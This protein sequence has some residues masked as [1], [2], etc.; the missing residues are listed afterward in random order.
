M[1]RKLKV[2]RA[3]AGFHDVYVAAPSQKAALEAWGA[4]HNLFASGAAE[5][6]IDPEL[7]AAALAKPGIVLKVLRGTSAEQ[8]AAL[9]D[10]QE[11]KMRPGS[12]E[13]ARIVPAKPKVGPRPGRAALDAAETAIAE[14][15]ERYRLRKEEL[16]QQE[17]AIERERA[18]LQKSQAKDALD[19]ETARDRAQKTY[20]RAIAE[21][22][23]GAD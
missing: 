8:L 4:S 6:V 5:V 19:A 18:K 3:A 2:F 22:K 17:A 9:G 15:E 7:V 12:K 20:D 23:R 16:D 1:G 10:R 21:W 11:T 13:R 14:T